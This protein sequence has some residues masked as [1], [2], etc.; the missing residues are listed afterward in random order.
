MPDLI[1]KLPSKIVISIK[2]EKDIHHKWTVAEFLEA[3]WNELILRSLTKQV[4]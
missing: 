3:F 1:K 4:A 2:R